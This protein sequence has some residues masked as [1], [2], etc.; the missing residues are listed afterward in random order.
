[1]EIH[2]KPIN[3]SHSGLCDKLVDVYIH[4]AYAK[5][6]N[7]QLVLNSTI[8]NKHDKSKNFHAN[9]FQDILMENILS[10]CSFS[11]NIIVDVDKD[12]FETI[13]DVEK[14]YIG[15]CYPIVDFFDKY[16]NSNGMCSLNDYLMCFEKP[17][18]CFDKLLEKNEDMLDIGDDCIGLHL[19]RTDK[20]AKDPDYGQCNEKENEYYERNTRTALDKM[21]SRGCSKFFICGDDK[22][23]VTDYMLYLK[24]H[25]CSVYINDDETH[26]KTYMDLYCLSKCKVI[27]MSSKHSNFSIIGS[28]LGSRKIITVWSHEEAYKGKYQTFCVQ[29]NCVI[30]FISFQDLDKKEVAILGH[31]GVADFYNQCGLFN[32]IAGSYYDA[33]IT[34]LVESELTIDMVKGLFPRYDVCVAKVRKD[35]YDGVKSCLVCHTPCDINRIRCLRDHGREPIF[36]D[37]EYYMNKFVHVRALNCFHDSPAW[38]RARVGKAFNVAFCH[39][40]YCHEHVLRSRFKICDIESLLCLD[41]VDCDAVVHDDPQRNLNVQIMHINESR[42]YRVNGR[43]KMMIDM[44]STMN[45]VKEIHMIDSSYSVML[46]CVQ[47]KYGKNGLFDSADVY[48]HNSSRPGREITI[49]THNMHRNWR[50]V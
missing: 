41:Y 50:V 45:N 27:I 19:R 34:L 46:W 15:G 25:G 39:Y 10:Y 30:D 5:C 13:D 36:L 43:S 38:E 9:R 40:N 12:E 21:I 48:L 16:L 49:Y 33:K 28:L 24:S 29:W 35:F 32:L 31:Q 6:N 22:N 23:I 4:N 2:H 44:L 3:I 17:I 18:L 47:H 37:E 8:F 20:V 1:M 26:V 11:E 42:V 14:L 7:K